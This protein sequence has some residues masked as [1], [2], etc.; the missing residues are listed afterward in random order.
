MVVYD[1]A[2]SMPAVA[3]WARLSLIVWSGMAPPLLDVPG[4][5]NE[6]MGDVE[7]QG[8]HFEHMLVKVIQE[9]YPKTYP[10]W[11]ECVDSSRG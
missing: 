11:V 5:A 7:A 3:I 2:S 10:E 8:Q 9:A 1:F 6:Q 4:E